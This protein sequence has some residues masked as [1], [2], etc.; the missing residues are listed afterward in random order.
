[1]TPQNLQNTAGTSVSQQELAIQSQKLIY[2]Q[3]AREQLQKQRKDGSVASLT[4]A[5]V[6][7]VG[8]DMSD[9]QTSF[10][11][12]PEVL[13][14][15]WRS[16]QELSND[17][18]QAHL[19]TPTGGS[20]RTLV[21][22]DH[23]L[24]P[25]KRA[26]LQPPSVS[27]AASL[28]QEQHDWVLANQAMELAKYTKSNGA[29]T[30][31]NSRAG[32]PRNNSIDIEKA[33]PLPASI[34]RSKSGLNNTSDH[35]VDHKVELHD[36]IGAYHVK[37]PVEE[38]PHPSDHLSHSAG[39]SRPPAV[40]DPQPS[41]TSDQSTIT[42]QTNFS[43]EATGTRHHP[44]ASCAQ[45]PSPLAIPENFPI[46]LQI[47][48]LPSPSE[49]D[50]Q[51]DEND[52]N[53][54]NDSTI[55]TTQQEANPTEQK[56]TSN[57]VFGGF[58]IAAVM[59]VVSFLLLEKI[60][61]LVGLFSDDDQISN[62]PSFAP[63][64]PPPTILA[65]TLSPTSAP[66]PNAQEFLPNLPQFTVDAIYNSPGS[67][68]QRAYDWILKDRKLNTDMP[69]WKVLQ[70]Y[71]LATLYYATNIATSDT[72]DEV[73][74]YDNVNWLSHSADECLDWVHADM[75]PFP[76]QRCTT[77]GH[78]E[79]IDLANHGLAGY[80]PPE[81]SFLTHLKNIN[82]GGNNLRQ[83]SQ[84]LPTELGLLTNLI[85]FKHG[86]N[87]AQ[88]SIPTELGRLTDLTVFDVGGD[89]SLT[90]NL[91]SEFGH[92]SYLKELWVN[93][94]E[95]SGSLPSE[96]GNL[97][98][99]DLKEL[100]LEDNGFIGSLPD[101]LGEALVERKQNDPDVYKDDLRIWLERNEFTGTVPQ[102]FCSKRFAF[103]MG[104]GTQELCGCDDFCPCDP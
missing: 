82:V 30:T 94:N 11:R 99:F 70:R 83:T 55:P 41:A 26:A 32:V 88:G 101:E 35:F 53:N 18:Q 38:G 46:A 64:T 60:F 27:P 76:I 91:P 102:D 62:S 68:Q 77:D 74:W 80:L 95:M 49:S 69:E 5:T 10:R 13:K 25:S 36:Y 12:D 67:P 48:M 9:S 24:S 96:V 47:H 7:T 61:N 75:A 8:D 66:T 28:S 72:E 63:S 34:F 39:Y 22:S 51:H 98:K 42:P 19:Q 43:D 17:C 92:M 86:S 33:P 90:G 58:F 29:S 59:C 1:M 79:S 73:A 40:I 2:E 16:Q 56:S 100:R 14:K 84:A 15:A 23:Q 52:N 3:I 44:S 85:V 45:E 78:Y 103:K 20:N 50:R 87:R 65:T 89:N 6:A 21:G 81:I 57:Y 37:A 31:T 4:H 71:A 54:N 104:C 93:N 97:L